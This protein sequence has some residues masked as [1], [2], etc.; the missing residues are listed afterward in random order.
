M[1]EREQNVVKLAE[2]VMGW[3]ED[4]SRRHRDY[5]LWRRPGKCCINTWKD[6]PGGHINP[7]CWNPYESI[8]DAW[9]LVERIQGLPC[10]DDFNWCVTL[11]G[12]T[13]DWCCRI[14]HPIDV[15]EE[16]PDFG[17]LYCEYGKTAPEAICA[18]ALAALSESIKPEAA[19]V[20]Q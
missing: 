11:Y 15:G 18:A 12:T 1:T 9:M 19:G 20:D 3:T 13:G 10:S 14:H 2:R 16:E 4:V 17:K 5:R 6:A 8:A 7:H